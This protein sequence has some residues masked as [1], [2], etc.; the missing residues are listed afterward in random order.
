MQCLSFICFWPFLLMVYWLRKDLQEFLNLKNLFV[1]IIIGILTALFFEIC[2]FMLTAVSLCPNVYI[3]F[4]DNMSIMST[5]IPREEITKGMMTAVLLLVLKLCN[6]RISMRWALVL[7]PFY[8]CI[9]F[10]WNEALDYFNH[11]GGNNTFLGRA[12]FPVHLIIQTPMVY[13]LFNYFLGKGRI[14]QLFIFCCSIIAAICTHFLWNTC[15]MLDN[16]ICYYMAANTHFD[17]LFYAS[18]F[19]KIICWILIIVWGIYLWLHIFTQSANN[20]FKKPFLKKMNGHISYIFM[21][22]VYAIP[23]FCSALIA[24]FIAFG[25]YQYDLQELKPINGRTSMAAKRKFFS[26]L[27]PK[28]RKERI[29]C[30]SIGSSH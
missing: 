7:T 20:I 17:T 15:V 18:N 22:R 26:C 8:I 27:T 23:G 9:L 30:T 4:L 10:S 25:L 3:P 1:M 5:L 2:P 19:I 28:L 21:H 11:P 29:I 13:I 16:D 24:L 6:P 14:H 12:L